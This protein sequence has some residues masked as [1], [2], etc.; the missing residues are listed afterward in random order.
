MWQV[1]FTDI[2]EQD[3]LNA[4]SYISEILKAPVAAENLIL[5]AERAIGNLSKF[6]LSCPLVEDE[7]FSTTGVRFLPIKNYLAFYI[8]NESTQVISVIRFL[9]ARRDWIALLG[10]RN[11]ET[12]EGANNET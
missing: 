10:N 3:L 4:S 1:V 12:E 9:Y 2:A 7:Y 11:M 6:P 8:A 5:E